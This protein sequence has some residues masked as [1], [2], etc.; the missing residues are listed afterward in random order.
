MCGANA[1]WQR[2]FK[3]MTQ[4]DSTEGHNVQWE[5]SA[6]INLKR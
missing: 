1:Q 3:E 6:F 2:P 4:R 5:Y